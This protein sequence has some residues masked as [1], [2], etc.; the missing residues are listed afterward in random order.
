MTHTQQTNPYLNPTQTNIDQTTPS[1]PKCNPFTIH[2]P[3][4]LQEALKLPDG[5]KW[6]Q[7]WNEEMVRLE[8][9]STW[10]VCD[11]SSTNDTNKPIKSKFVFKIKVNPDGNI[12]YKVRLCACGYSQKYGIDYDETF[13]PTAKFKS[14]TT[15]LSIA[16]MFQW[17]LTGIDVENAF[18]EAKLDKPIYMNLPT[19]TYSN[20]DESPLKVKLLKSLYGLKQASELWDKFLPQIK[21]SDDKS[22]QNI[23]RQFNRRIILRV[24]PFHNLQHNQVHTQLCN[25]RC[26]QQQN[27]RYNL[28]AH[29]QINPHNNHL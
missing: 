27:P 22:Y 29:Q 6:R 15:I 11:P 21:N 16:A 8:S 14:V 1:S 24:N 28:L 20:K 12:R 26:S 10:I 3:L 19:S 2:T 25:H 7:A 23:N 4:T 17:E 13:A 5:D 18:V 9:R